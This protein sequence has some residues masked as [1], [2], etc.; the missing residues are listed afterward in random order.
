MFSYEYY[1]ANYKF[2]NEYFFLKQNWY[3]VRAKTA[4]MQG[5]LPL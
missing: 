3:D 2:W 4:K 1:T 5:E